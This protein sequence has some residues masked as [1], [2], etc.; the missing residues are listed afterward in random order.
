MKKRL[1]ISIKVII[2][3]KWYHHSAPIGTDEERIRERLTFPTAVEL[4]LL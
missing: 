1:N 2:S 3:A 4:Y